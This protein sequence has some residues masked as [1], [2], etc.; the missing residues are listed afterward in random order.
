M[1]VI[2]AVDLRGGRVVRLAQGDLSRQTAYSSDPVAVARRWER[3][4]ASRLH[5]VDLDGAFSGRPEQLAAVAEVVK[6]VGVPVQLGGGLRTL[7]AL[8]QAFAVG[9]D[10]AVVGTAAIEEPE[11]LVSACRRYPGRIVLGIDA[12]NGRV[13]V[14]GWTGETELRPTALVARSSALALAAIIYTDIGRDG[15]LAGAN[16]DALRQIALASPHPV[17]ASGGIATLEDIRQIAALDPSRIVGALI[18]KALYE[19][20]FSLREAIAVARS[21]AC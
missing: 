4:G 14:R 2:P 20:R 7:Q 18:G 21:G 17:I 15:M 16:L 1:L 19:G 6:A 3:E 12:K 11:W 13:A 5:L 10:R 9:I 8:D